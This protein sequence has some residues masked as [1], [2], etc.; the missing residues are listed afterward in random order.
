MQIVC[1]NKRKKISKKA[2]F[3]HFRRFMKKESF[4]E[5]AGLP[6]N[7]NYKKFI[8][9]ETPMIEAE[10]ELRSPFERDYTRILHSTA[11]RRLKHKTQVFYNIES[12]HICTRMEHVWHVESVSY[13]I[14]K[15]LGLNTELTRAIAVGH[16][17]GHAPFGHYGESVINKLHLAHLGTK[18]WHEKN[19]LYFCDN[20]ELL[21]NRENLN[22]NL[23]LTYAVRDGIISHCG[24]KDINQIVPRKNYIDLKDFNLPGEYNPATFEGCVVK[25]S[26]KI[27]YVGRDIEDAINLGFLTENTLKELSKIVKLSEN[28]VIN[29][30]SIMRNMIYDICECSSPD[31]GICLSE[32]MSDTLNKIKQFNYK[33]VYDNERFN[34]FKK[35]A[36]LILHDIFEILYSAYTPENI[37]TSLKSREKKYPNLMREFRDYLMKYMDSDKIP[38]KYATKNENYRNKKIYNDISNEKVYV[39]AIFDYIAGMTDRYAVKLFEELINY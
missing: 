20:I 37:F 4:Y 8:E 39:K 21:P 17:L 18:F 34:S 16:D 15:C 1:Y 28:S 30:S 7:K 5:V 22:K 24:E 19:S 2:L 14:A 10:N 11:F 26:D 33:Y 35:Y 12:D 13:T 25:I 6:H 23:N 27:A 38:A 3:A 9:R 31:K 29:T 32:E 36:E